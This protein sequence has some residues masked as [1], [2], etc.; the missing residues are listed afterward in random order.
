MR[1]L[2]FLMIAATSIAA[3]HKSSTLPL[4]TPVPVETISK[5][6][7]IRTLEHQHELNQEVIGELKAA[8]GVIVSE[9]TKELAG[10]KVS[11]DEAKTEVV[12]VQTIIDTQAEKISKQE[13]EIARY[14][15]LL[16]MV[17]TAF[18]G[19][20]ALLTFELLKPTGFIG[21]AFS[22]APWVRYAAPVIVFGIVFGA[23]WLYF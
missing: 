19:L 16:R 6:D 20:A 22:F 1:I 15:R 3:P 18:A 17:C 9:L 5:A 23:A 4:A 7:I 21:M 2:I 14:H 8:N 10:A 11:L 13:K 12:K